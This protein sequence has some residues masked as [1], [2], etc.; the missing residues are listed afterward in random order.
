MKIN[1]YIVIIFLLSA[2]V[3]SVSTYYSINSSKL[4]AG[5]SDRVYLT[6]HQISRLDKIYSNLSIAD[7]AVKNYIITGNAKLLIPP[8]SS[9]A[10]LKRTLRSLRRDMKGDSSLFTDSKRLETLAN[11]RIKVLDKL[12][13]ER[14]QSFDSAKKMVSTG[15]GIAQMD[16]IKALVDRMTAKERLQRT[17]YSTQT[18][19][20]VDKT[21][22]T[23]IVSGI[24]TFLIIIIV[25]FFLSRDERRIQRSERKFRDV[26]TASPFAIV[27]TDLKTGKIQSINEEFT[28]MFGFTEKDVKGYSMVDLGA[29]S[30]EDRTMIIEDVRVNGTSRNKEFQFRTK[31]GDII[32][33]LFS[34]IILDIDETPSILALFSNITEL[35]KLQHEL[36]TAKELAEKSVREKDVFLANMSHEIRT[37]MNAIIGFSDLL[38]STSLEDEQKDFLNVISNAGENLLVIINDI[39]DF[40]KIESG[41]LTMEKRPL[42]LKVLLEYTKKL[43]LLKADEKQI[44]LNFYYESDLPEFIIGDQVRLN[45][46]LINLI[47]NAIK[48]TEEGK[49]EVRTRTVS[50][51]GNE[52]TLEISVKDTGIG[53]PEDKLETIFERFKQG[54][55]NTTRKYGGTG[56]GLSIT[57]R[58]IELC[59]GQIKL[60]SKIGVGSEFI[61]QIP[62]EMAQ[63]VTDADIT[64]EAQIDKICGLNILI[65]E[66]NELNQKLAIRI[67]KKANT[68]SLAV[69]GQ[70]AIDRVKYQQFDIILMDLQMPV[71]DGY[72]ATKYIREVLKNTTP[73][74]ALTAHSIGEEKGKSLE[75]GINEYLSK[76]YKAH[77]LLQKIQNQIQAGKENNSKIK[78]EIKEEAPID[79]KNNKL[80]DLSL[81]Q[82]NSD[83]DKEFIQESISIFLRDMSNN[84]DVLKNSLLEEKYE[85]IRK[86]AHK[87]KSSLSLFKADKAV[88]LC[89][90]IEASSEDNVIASS[91]HELI[92]SVTLITETFK[93]DFPLT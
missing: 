30:Q 17:Q 63:K 20:S 84:I 73:I 34:N 81:I 32:T 28:F 50:K 31:S 91:I 74:I 75:Y 56:L 52:C 16:T 19:V 77:E 14:K 85:D 51:N 40:S 54:D 58:L 64:S 24:G 61:I 79:E 76:P 6:Q 45:Q 67:L 53:I 36:V 29:L 37:P 39:L 35:K 9:A 42:N 47:G 55:D 57:K 23:I 12:A 70:E 38:K 88:E 86:L 71:M 66:D 90:K 2:V 93:R 3:V 11:A 44:G 8:D 62:F 69:N 1:K 21:T 89:K 49:V 43:L 48:F 7:N 59:G 82:E 27:I 18:Q 13:K 80:Y 46:I 78:I 5:L 22:Q 15:I 60:N 4:A 72:T 83:N 33:T 26:F 10:R 87:M 65:V 41:N 68:V 25:L 92:D